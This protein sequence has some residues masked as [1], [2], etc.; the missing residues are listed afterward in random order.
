MT[1]VRE[2]GVPSTRK[3]SMA[4]S[5]SNDNIGPTELSYKERDTPERCDTVSL[6]AH[7]STESASGTQ[8]GTVASHS[9]PAFFVNIDNNTDT[10]NSTAIE[11]KCP[12]CSIVFKSQG[13]IDIHIREKHP[14]DEITE[15]SSCSSDDEESI[16]DESDSDF[17]PSGPTP[18]QDKPVK[19]FQCSSCGT[20][21]T[22]QENLKRHLFRFRRCR[23]L[24][25]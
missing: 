24:E 14:A 1:S 18:N 22:R 4:D 25:R 21:F 15:S 16:D 2:K 12:H 3:F 19:G 20:S 23:T 13:E 8:V 10:E 6:A 17:V 9:S 11:L 5:V 7:E